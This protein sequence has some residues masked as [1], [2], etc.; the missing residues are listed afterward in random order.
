MSFV[1][2][3]PSTVIAWKLA[4]AASR[5]AAFRIRGTRGDVRHDERE[6]RRHVRVDHARRPSRPRRR[7]RAGPSD[8]N[9]ACATFGPTSVVRIACEAASSARRREARLRVGKRRADLRVRQDDA[10]HA[11]G[12]RRGPLASGS[13]GGRPPRRAPGAR[14][15]APAL[16]VTAFAHPAFTTTARTRPPLA[17]RSAF[18]EKHGGRLEPVLREEGGGVRAVLGD[19]ERDV[20]PPSCGCPRALPRR[21]SPSA[22]SSGAPREAPHGRLRGPRRPGAGP[23]RR[24]RRR[25][26]SARRTSR[27]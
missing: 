14:R 19:E 24:R 15:R 22:V 6:H 1:D 17:F 9:D 11:R 25:F 8:A 26:A 27:A 21:G 2:V 20:G 4:S 16:P 5:S 18:A 10:D 12:R 7:G 13:R 23:C 3:S